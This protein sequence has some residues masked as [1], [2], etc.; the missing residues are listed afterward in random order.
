M[1]H[2][3]VHIIQSY[4]R[5]RD[6][7]GW[8]VEGIADYIRFWR[9]EPEAPRPRINTDKS[10]YRDSYRTAGAFLAWIA[11]KY[12]RRIIQT[13][14]HALRTG[15]YHEDLFLQATGKPLDP[16]WDEFAASYR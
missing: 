8:L 11:W 14:D 10:S 3:L 2:E 15:T 6:K 12:D 5:S 1:I 13:L 16:L 7:P 9:Y 4:P